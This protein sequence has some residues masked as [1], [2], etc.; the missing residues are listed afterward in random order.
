METIWNM[1]EQKLINYHSYQSQR[2]ADLEFYSKAGLRFLPEHKGL[3]MM[4][5][6]IKPQGLFMDIS[7]SAGFLADYKN[8]IILD[9]SLASLNTA[10]KTYGNQKILAASAIWNFDK[11]VDSLAIIP[12]GDKGNARVNAE[13]LGAY[14]VLNQNGL[15]Y[16]LLHKNQGAKRYEKEIK[17]TFGNIKVIAKTSGWRLSSAIKTNNR[18]ITI[19]MLSFRA[20]ELNLEAAAGVY[21]AGKL[22]PGSE[23]FLE[24]LDF[25]QFKNKKVLDIGTG[26]GILALKASLAAAMVTA[27]DDD[28]LAIQSSYKNSKKYGLDIRCLHSD[29]NSSLK[30]DD[31]YDYVITNPPF[32]VGKGVVL[33]LPFA[34]I[35]AAYKHLKPHGELFL[36]ANKALAYE[37][38]LAKFANWKELATNN[39]FKILWAKK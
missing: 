28:L 25:R 4:K 21:A 37:P 12:S 18:E 17:K 3:S 5:A 1:L 33:E 32:H 27:V 26:Y 36:V 13:I 8:S 20:A 7:S 22:D 6:K 10:K 29:V 35:A 11:Q 15:A 19:P 38:L 2:I 30:D 16:F 24:N 34:F 14:K 23:F 39:S 31:L 9:T